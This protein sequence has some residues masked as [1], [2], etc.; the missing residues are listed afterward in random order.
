MLMSWAHQHVQSNNR[1]YP[2]SQ[3][4]LA[5][6]ANSTTTI[7]KPGGANPSNLHV[8]DSYVFIFTSSLFIPLGWQWK[9]RAGY[10]RDVLGSIG[11]QAHSVS[12]ACS[13]QIREQRRSY[14]QIF[15]NTQKGGM[16]VTD[17]L[18]WFLGCLGH[19]IDKANMLT[20]SVFERTRSGN[21]S[22]KSQS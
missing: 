11:E 10:R 13:S 20:A 3:P 12:T 2:R 8:I 17:W 14:Y 6:G 9:N 19:A 18:T 1:V 5:G 7:G 22:S 21:D 16:D 4:L 15:E